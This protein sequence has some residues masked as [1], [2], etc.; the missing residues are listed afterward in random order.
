[1]ARWTPGAAEAA[2]AEAATWSRLAGLGLPPATEAEVV[3]FYD[4]GPDLDR[5]AGAWGHRLPGH[6][7]AEL[8]R[9]A[10]ALATAEAEAWQRDEPHVATRAYE[11]R[12]FLVGDRIVHWVMPWL[13]AEG[14]IAARDLL[15]E[16]GDL[17]RPAPA[18]GEG[19]A[20]PGEDAFGPLAVEAPLADRV[21]SLWSGIVL[22]ARLATPEL[23]EQAS[24]RW[25]S[26]A[27]AHPGTAGLWRDLAA[28]AAGT[29]VELRATRPPSR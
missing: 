11:D 17:H 19:A 23:Y 10:A 22:G 28:R 25:R 20:P 13:D 18:G 27:A 15:L 9:F 16:L 7:F 4:P 21:R 8:A 5:R 6:H 24:A 26:L 29:A 12:R 2:R 14:A 3:R 1:M